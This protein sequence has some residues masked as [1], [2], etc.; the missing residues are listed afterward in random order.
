[1]KE[2]SNGEY[3]QLETYNHEMNRKDKQIDR[4]KIKIKEYEEKLILLTSQDSNV[5]ISIIIKS[6]K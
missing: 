5:E 1:M 4:L 2:C 3:V 6:K